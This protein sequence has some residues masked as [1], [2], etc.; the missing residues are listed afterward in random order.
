MG[1]RFR[2]MFKS[3]NFSKNIILKCVLKLIFICK[4]NVL[5]V[6]NFIEAGNMVY[7]HDCLH[8]ELRSNQ[9]HSYS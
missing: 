6:L 8:R 5:Y 3:N 2:F 9:S 4:S 7:K 1:M